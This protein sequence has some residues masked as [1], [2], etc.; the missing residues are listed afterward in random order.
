MFNEELESK[1]DIVVN[2]INKAKNIN[3]L[4]FVNSNY[5]TVQHPHIGYRFG[6]KYIIFKDKKSAFKHLIHSASFG[7]NNTNIWINTGYANS[8]G[9][10]FYY[11]LTQY[12][13]NSEYNPI[14][15]KIFANSYIFLSVCI[16]SM[17]ER[18]YDSART[19]GKLIDNFHHIA[20]E[21]IIADYNI[22]GTNFPK[23]MLSLGD[24][25][26]ASIGLSKHG[27]DKD[28][29]NCLY[30]AD[31]NFRFLQNIPGYELSRKMNLSEIAGASSEKSR[32]FF[33]NLLDAYKKNIFNLST[34]EWNK[35]SLSQNNI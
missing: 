12:D 16:L 4:E 27:F 10:S 2:E 1:S 25:Y 3:D 14:L 22:D 30:W 15:S 33:M 31:E 9:H 34:E 7:L 6:E 8:I 20:T 26:L 29:A 19:R 11:L 24:Y 13:Y 28:S 35:I 32:T 17:K 18:A 5:A 23:E 21:K